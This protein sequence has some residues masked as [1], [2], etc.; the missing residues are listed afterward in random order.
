MKIKFFVIALTIFPFLAFVHPGIHKNDNGW[1]S[2]FN[3][4]NLDGWHQLNGHAKYSV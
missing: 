4:K 1:K 2:L 3:G